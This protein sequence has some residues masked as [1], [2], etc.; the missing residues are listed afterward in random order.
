MPMVRGRCGPTGRAALTAAPKGQF[1][2]VYPE[3]IWYRYVDTT[4][5]DEIVDRHL[6]GGET[7]ERL[8]I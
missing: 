6:I 1:L 2:V 4:D 5:I 7:V 3:G 8:R